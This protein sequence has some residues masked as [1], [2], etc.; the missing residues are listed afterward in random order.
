[1]RTLILAGNNDIMESIMQR[2]RDYAGKLCV[3]SE[4]R[5]AKLCKRAQDLQKMKGAK[6]F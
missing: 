5:L 6:V 1:M 4:F 3:G 2:D